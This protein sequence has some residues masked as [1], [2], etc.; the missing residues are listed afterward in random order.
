MNFENQR[1]R[2]VH[3]GRDVPSPKFIQ[4]NPVMFKKV[5]ILGEL[6]NS[7][8]KLTDEF[9]NEVVSNITNKTNVFT[10]LWT[11]DKEI[12]AKN[13][14][15]CELRK[16]S[17]E[18]ELSE[19]KFSFVKTVIREFLFVMGSFSFPVLLLIAFIK[20]SGNEISI[21]IILSVLV[22]LLITVIVKCFISIKEHE[23]NL[24]IVTEKKELIKKIEVELA[25]IKISKSVIAKE[26]FEK[27]KDV[28]RQHKTLSKALSFQVSF[29][30]FVSINDWV[31]MNEYFQQKKI[32]RGFRYY[33]CKA[34]FGKNGI[35]T[36]KSRN[37][38]RALFKYDP[39]LTQPRISKL[40]AFHLSF[41][42]SNC[43]IPF[44][45]SNKEFSSKSKD[46]ALENG[47]NLLTTE[48]FILLVIY[49]LYTPFIYPIFKYL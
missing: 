43:E 7:P 48:Q 27:S 4:R 26:H 20:G 13:R 9:E 37:G 8:C 44:Y 23:S 21:S 16:D 2:A 42:N 39:D 46:F 47:I 1:S 40:K 12:D 22:I 30:K 25:N 45:I 32:E 24:V 15:L 10:D 28:N 5:D 18:L 11:F 36:I 35:V 49:N 31:R 34:E 29:L 19:S 38:I 6:M 17:R 14:K 3:I 41:L 33:Y